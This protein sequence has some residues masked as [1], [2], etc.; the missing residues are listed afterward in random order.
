MPVIDVHTHMFT[1]QWLELLRK[2]GGKYNIQTRPDGQNEVFRGNTPVVIPQ[3]GHFDWELRIQH[4]D[5]AGIDI[6]VVSL[7]CPN[8][9]WGNEAPRAVLFDAYG[10]LF[11]VYSVGLLAE[12]LFPGHGQ[13]LGMLLWRDK[14]IEYTRLVTTS[15]HG[16]HYQPVLGADPRWPGYAS[17]GWAGPQRGQPFD[18][19]SG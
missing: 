19:R 12:Q 5:K 9:Y 8:V 2:E 14:Q 4:M 10:T 7:T 3:K 18:N 15:N 6:S 1:A 16:A 11:D 13:A 17:K